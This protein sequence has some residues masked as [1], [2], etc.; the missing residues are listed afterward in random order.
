M[1]EETVARLIL[2]VV[3]VPSMSGIDDNMTRFSM[4]RGERVE[5]RGGAASG[6]A[7]EDGSDLCLEA[8][9]RLEGE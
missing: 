1:E 6:I 5:G 8:D 4:P 3:S 9:F 7:E 2:I